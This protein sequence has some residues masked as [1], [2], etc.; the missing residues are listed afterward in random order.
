MAI[1]RISF[2]H[3]SYYPRCL[4]REKEGGLVDDR[5]YPLSTTTSKWSSEAVLLKPWQY[6]ISVRKRKTNVIK[7]NNK[8]EKTHPAIYL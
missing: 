1:G 2:D 7:L 3:A 5:K 6:F 4:S 8:F